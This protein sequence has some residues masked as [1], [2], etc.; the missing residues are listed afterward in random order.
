MQDRIIFLVIAIEVQ[1]LKF[2]IR[3]CL[4]CNVVEVTLVICSLPLLQQLSDLYGLSSFSFQT[5]YPLLFNTVAAAASTVRIV[6]QRRSKSGCLYTQWCA[7]APFTNVVVLCL[8][9]I[10]Q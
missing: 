2:I 10:L 4:V 1:V 7:R 3:N 5:F 9:P 8:S 6:R